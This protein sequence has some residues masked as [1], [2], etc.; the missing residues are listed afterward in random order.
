MGNRMRLKD[1][2]ALLGAVLNGSMD[3]VQFERCE[4]FGW[5]VPVEAPNIDPALLQPRNTWADQEA[6]DAKADALA[7]RFNA[8]FVQFEAGVSE[9]VREA[10]PKA[11]VT[12][13]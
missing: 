4:R 12:A 2:R 6:F 3:Q 13:N 8:N 5:D 11:V 10:A 9:A 1:T 7:D